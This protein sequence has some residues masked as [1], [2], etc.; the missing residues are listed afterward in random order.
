M[1][2]FEPPTPTRSTVVAAAM[3]QAANEQLNLRVGI[4]RNLFDAFW[5]DPETTPDD[6]LTALGSNAQQFV[7]IAFE[8]VEHIATLAAIFN[9]QLSD[10]IDEESSMPR[11]AFISG[12]NGTVTLAPP[13]EGFNAWGKEIPITE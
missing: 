8:N 10:F 4:Q 7:A 13:A 2:L 3:M 12:D 9:K 6:I 11:R 1:K 5:N